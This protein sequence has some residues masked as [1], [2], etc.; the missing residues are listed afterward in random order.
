DHHIVRERDPSLRVGVVAHGGRAGALTF[1]AVPAGV[2]GSREGLLVVAALELV[3]TLVVLDG[4]ASGAAV[5]VHLE[6]A[7]LDVVAADRELLVDGVVLDPNSVAVQDRVA[8]T[9]ESQRVAD[10]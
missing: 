2:A 8:G 6:V 5:V 1:L 9:A 7:A 3:A 4:L 10:E